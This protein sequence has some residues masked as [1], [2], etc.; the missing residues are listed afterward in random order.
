VSG[1]GWGISARERAEGCIHACL[2]SQIGGIS[3][4]QAFSPTVTSTVRHHVCPGFVL[5]PSMLFRT[6]CLLGSVCLK[7]VIKAFMK[8]LNSIVAWF[9]QGRIPGHQKTFCFEPQ[10]R[11]L[12]SRRV[13]KARLRLTGKDGCKYSIWGPRNYKAPHSG[14]LIQRL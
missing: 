7:A 6:S 8:S 4:S 9:P 13:C 2:S 5:F 10:F 12:Q 1:K 3:L 14:I 11:L